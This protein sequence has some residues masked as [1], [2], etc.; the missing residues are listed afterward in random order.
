MTPREGAPLP[1]GPITVR[2]ATPGDLDAI[3]AIEEASFSAPWPR[4]AMLDEIVKNDWSVVLVA[5]LSGEIVGF[6]VYWVV[7][8]ERHLQNLA[9]TPAS[10]RLGVGDALVRH[11]VEDG[12]RGGAQ[13]VVLEVRASNEAAKGLYAGF[14]FQSIGV[15]RKYYQDNDEDAIVMVLALNEGEAW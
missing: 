13:F 6:A 5:A 2:R 7:A 12:K 15:R 3:M 1:E 4:D 8:D 14:G 10:R 9:T 11:V